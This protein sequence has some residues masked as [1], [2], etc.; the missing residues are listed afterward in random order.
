MGYFPIYL[1]YGIC[2]SELFW[3]VCCL[4][5]IMSTSDNV[6]Y[7]DLLPVDEVME[8]AAQYHHNWATGQ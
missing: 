6:Q 4:L 2:K 5:K 8:R 3:I 7:E 1:S